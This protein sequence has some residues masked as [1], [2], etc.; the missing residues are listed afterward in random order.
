MRKLRLVKKKSLLP[1]RV[2]HHFFGVFSRGGTINNGCGSQRYDFACD[3]SGNRIHHPFKGYPLINGEYDLLAVKYAGGGTLGK[4]PVKTF[5]TLEEAIAFTKKYPNITW[6]DPVQLANGRWQIKGKKGSDREVDISI[7]DDNFTG[8]ARE[9]SAFKRNCG[10][11]I[12]GQNV[13]SMSLG[14][15]ASLAKEHGA[16]AKAVFDALTSKGEDFIETA[17]VSLSIG[18]NATKEHVLRTGQCICGQGNKIKESSEDIL[19]ETNTDTPKKTPPEGDQIAPRFRIELVV[20]AY[21]P[22]SPHITEANGRDKAPHKEPLVVGFTVNSDSIENIQPSDITVDRV[23]R[24]AVSGAHSGMQTTHPT[25]LGQATVGSENDRIDARTFWTNDKIFAKA[26][27][28]RLF[29]NPEMRERLARAMKK[30]N[31]TNRIGGLKKDGGYEYMK[32]TQDGEGELERMKRHGG[33]IDFINH[34]FTC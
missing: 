25:E 11:C 20:Y 28:E 30:S 19:V 29:S 33:I 26:A 22:V 7:D 16:S 3:S 17:E 13:I 10:P 21:G 34:C 6:G 14:Q 8:E 32:D 18:K 2:K 12:A 31:T 4:N 5:E 15:L 23:V 24:K 1:K 9:D 27:L